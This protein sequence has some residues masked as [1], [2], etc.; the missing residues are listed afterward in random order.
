MFK[1]LTKGKAAETLKETRGSKQVD[2]INPLMA[3]CHLVDCT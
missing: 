2:C 1:I 3:E